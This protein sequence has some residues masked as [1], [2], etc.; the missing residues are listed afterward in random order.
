MKEDRREQSE[1]SS[2][3]VK[4]C[5]V[6]TGFF[7]LI[8]VLSFR[9]VNHMALKNHLSTHCWTSCREHKVITQFYQNNVAK[10]YPA[11]FSYWNG[12]YAGGTF[13][14]VLKPNAVPTARPQSAWHRRSSQASRSFPASTAAVP[15]VPVETASEDQ[16]LI[17]TP[18]RSAHRGEPCG[19]PGYTP[20]P[21][22]L[23]RDSLLH[24][25]VYTMLPVQSI[26]LP[27]YI[28]LCIQ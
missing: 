16:P 19:E 24:H 6:T 5:N 8:N 14:L 20:G 3:Q 15:A 23:Q 11:L 10:V 9:R 12:T 7:I 25:A 4:F 22:Q 28:A 1:Q 2:N 26:V 13:V 27:V 17:S 21:R 18:P